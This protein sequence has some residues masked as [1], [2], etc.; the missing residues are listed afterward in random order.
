[1]GSFYCYCD[2]GYILLS[3]RVTP[4]SVFERVGVDYVGPVYVKL[5]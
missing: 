2:T 1:M 5:K 4:D 3:E